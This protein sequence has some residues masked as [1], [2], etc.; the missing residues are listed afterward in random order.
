[1]TRGANPDLQQR[2]KPQFHPKYLKGGKAWHTPQGGPMAVQCLGPS[3]SLS[4][5]FTVRC[6]VL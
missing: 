6:A 2:Y 5:A 4:K 1:M 3:A